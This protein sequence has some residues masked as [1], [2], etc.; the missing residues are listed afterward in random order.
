MKYIDIKSFLKCDIKPF[1]CGAFLSRIMEY[2]DDLGNS[3]FYAYSK[4]KSSKAIYIDDFDFVNYSKIFLDTLNRASGFYNWSICSVSKN[5][6]ELRFYVLNSINMSKSMF[7][8]KIYQK[9]MSSSWILSNDQNESKKEFVRGFMELRGSVDTTAKYITQD[10]FYDNRLELKK[11]QILTDLMNIPAEYVNF[12]ARDL[13]PQFVNGI[14]KRNAQ[15]RINSLYYSNNIG[16]INHYKAQV[17]EHTYHSLGKRIQGDI[18]YYAVNMPNSRGDDIAFIRYL[19]F[20]T[21]NIYEKKLTKETIKILREK[22]NFDTK[23]NYSSKRNISLVSL[24]DEISEDKCAICGTTHT[25]ENRSTGRQY[26]EIHHV[27]SFCNGQEADNI[28]NLIKLCPTCHDMLK[29]N[30]ANKETQV[31]AIR[32][33]LHEHEEIFEFASSYLEIDD[34]NDLSEK[35]WLMLG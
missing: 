5:S 9:L 22:L 24:F 30:R 10:Y 8:R 15:F 2:T 27:I 23:S 18:I 7:Y 16:F 1:V 11:A 21:N 17:F 28:A 29:R 35:I 4:F 20:F 34:I 13:Q 25:F 14:S 19:N 12:N 32:K 3:Y 31:N 6:M 33:I 26:F